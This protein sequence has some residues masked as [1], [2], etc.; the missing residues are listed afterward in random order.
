MIMKPGPIVR[1]VEEVVPRGEGIPVILMSPQGRVFT[2]AVAEE[3]AAHDRIALVCGHYEGVDERVR[4]LV[5]TDEISIGDYVLTGGEL[6]AMVVV[7]AVTRL[8]PD[9][10]GDPDAPAKDSHATGLLEHPHYTRPP[11]FRGLT[12]PDVLVSGHAAKIAEW[13]RQ[14]SIRRTWQRRPEMLVDFDFTEKEREFL[15]VLAEERI[16]ELREEKKRQ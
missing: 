16:A 5:I 11:E 13:R 8:L 14:Q 12:V 4:D 3:L 15:V 9:V 2:Q 7:D 6:A 10:L 1:A